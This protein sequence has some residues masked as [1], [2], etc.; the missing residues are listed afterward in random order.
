M[1]P[2]PII[3]EGYS[4]DRYE[5]PDVGTPEQDGDI[6]PLKQLMELGFSRE[7]AVTALENSN[8]NFQRALNKLLA[9]A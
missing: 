6:P 9:A 5:A 4:N 8:Y 1:P 3:P 7:K 2:V